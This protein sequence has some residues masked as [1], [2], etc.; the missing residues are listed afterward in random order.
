[1][2]YLLPM[3]TPE[4]FNLIARPVPFFKIENQMFDIQKKI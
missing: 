4:A 3:V 2:L 1:L